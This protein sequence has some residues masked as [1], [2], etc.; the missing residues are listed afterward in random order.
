MYSKVN[1]AIIGIFVVLF[2]LG[3]IFFAF[4]LGNTG[5]K[6]DFDLYLVRM[7]ESV[8]GLSKDSG[9]K[10]KGVDIGTVSDIRINPKNIEEIE[11]ILKI[12]KG[13][14]IKEDMRGVISMY[15]LTGLSFVNIEG[16]SNRSKRLKSIDGEMPVIQAG[17]STLN[18]LEDKFEDLSDKLLSIMK[19]GEEVLSDE[20]LK[21]FSA[22]LDNANQ[23]AV[24]G[25]AVEDKIIATLDEAESALKEFNES[26]EKLSQNFDSLAID[27]HKEIKPSL[28]KFNSM[29]KSIDD[30]SA[31][32]HKTV[33]RGDYNMQK[34]M[35]PT[36]NDLREVA[37]QIDALTRQLRESPSDLLYKSGQPRRGPGE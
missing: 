20:N 34:I 4:W 35:Q 25:T 12:K 21:N 31:Q 5:F 37:E 11:I 14:P 1:Y 10:L 3:I 9:V 33:N 29:T 18:N 15:G 2:T 28:K 22:L 27:L 30:L 16:G 19:R 36:I 13:I 6:D 17:I 24:K 26:F 7:K 8:S 32:I 23:V